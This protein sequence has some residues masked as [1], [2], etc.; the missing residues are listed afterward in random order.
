MLVHRWAVSHATIRLA[1]LSRY[2][3]LYRIVSAFQTASGSQAVFV[4]NVV[5]L[6]KCTRNSRHRYKQGGNHEQ[7]HCVPPSFSSN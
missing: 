5:G 2:T 4:M 7:T 6:R 3:L 1:A